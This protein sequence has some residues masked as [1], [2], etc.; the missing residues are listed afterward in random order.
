MEEPERKIGVA[1]ISGTAWKPAG[2]E[3]KGRKYKLKR[4]REREDAHLRLTQ[5]V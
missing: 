4:D 5:Y 1:L 2:P 3:Q